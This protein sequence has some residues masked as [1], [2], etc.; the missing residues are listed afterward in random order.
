MRKEWGEYA[1]KGVNSHRKAGGG[2]RG[3]AIA[4]K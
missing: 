1:K 4:G 2:G 3:G